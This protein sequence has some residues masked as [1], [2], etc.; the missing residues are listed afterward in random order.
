MYAA[1]FS[2]LT[3]NWCAAEDQVEKTHPVLDCWRFFSKRDGIVAVQTVQSFSYYFLPTT[4]YIRLSEITVITV[5]CFPK[6]TARSS[7]GIRPLET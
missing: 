6:I 7:A 2:L 3:G 4:W 1:G 5:R